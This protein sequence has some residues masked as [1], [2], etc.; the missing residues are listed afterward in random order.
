MKVLIA[1]PPLDTDKG[2]PLLSQ[3]RQFQYFKEPTY[4]YPV[5]PAS[6]ATMLKKS[7]HEVV[8]LD[9]IA[10][11]LSYEDFLKKVTE[12]KPDLIAL[13]T[14]TPVVKRHWQII[15]EL[16][17]RA[18]GL[19]PM[20]TVLFGDHV[21]ALPEESFLN[22]SVDYVLT[23][24]DYDFLLINLC[25]VLSHRPCL[26]G[27]Q[28]PTIDHRLFEPG[29]W[30][31]DNGQVKNTGLFKLD[32]D[33]DSA[34]VIDRDL[35]QWKLYAYK[36]G[37]F[38]RTPGAYIMAGR[39]CWWGKCT[40]CLEPAINITTNKGSIAIKDIVDKNHNFKNGLLVLTHEGIFRRVT[41]TYRHYYNGFL[42][43]LE[44]FCLKNRLKLTPNH[45]VFA[46][47]RSLMKRCSKKCSWSYLCVPGRIS[48]RL[49]CSKCQKQYYK[50]YLPSFIESEKLAKGDFVAV[51]IIRKVKDITCINIKD[52]LESEPPLV[53]TQKKKT[54][55]LIEEIVGEYK[56]GRSQRS[57]ARDL[58]IDRGTVKRYIGLHKSGQLN[59]NY[60]LIAEVD[61]YIKYEY[62]KKWISKRLF[63]S[64]DFLRLVGYY[65]AEGSVSKSGN[66]PNSYSISFTFSSKET[67]YITDVVKI[68]SKL[69][70]KIVVRQCLNQKNKTTQITIN[71]SILAILFLRL[72][73]A[74]SYEKKIPC[75]YLYL[76]LA[77]QRELLRGLFRGD[78][79]LRIRQKSKGGTE[80]ILETVSDVMANQILNI[81]FRFDAIPRFRLCPISKKRKSPVYS[82][83]LCQYDIEKVFRNIE[84]PGRSMKYRHGFILD[85]WA[86]VPIKD[87]TRE[88]YNGFLYNLEVGKDHSYVAGNV[89]V[90]N[91]SW[92]TLYPEFRS[93]KPENVVDEIEGLIND[94]GVK[95]IMDDSGCFPAGK[96]L[97]DFCEIMIKRGIGK[98]INLDCNMRFGALDLKQYKLMKQAGFR[99]VLFGLESANQ[100][101]L[102]HINKNVKADV[103]IDSCKMARQAGLYPHITI[104]FGYPWETYEDALR[105]LNLGRWLLK[106]GFAYTVQATIVIPYPGS[107]LFDECRD[108]GLLKSLDWE[109]YDM[110]APVMK[111]SI[112]DSKVKS[113]VQGI[114]SVAFDPEFIFNRIVSIRDLS[115]L[116]YFFRGVKKVSG[117]L[118]D[119]NK[120]GNL[121]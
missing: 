84:L 81:L 121:Q 53:N 37:N 39:D 43:N 20:A 107:K 70:K 58:Q 105:T 11:G 106:K 78:G 59:A 45:K 48:K 30:Y 115:D 74:N 5:V 49:D 104:M 46:I 120:L 108:S 35:T 110:K 16:K 100:V 13:E 96:W 26:A 113:L 69:W 111:T 51:P 40:F 88:S 63:L 36:N 90:S 8:W 24:G 25:S 118:F 41:K 33:L 44:L 87:I 101:T 18:D 62:G 2:V 97:N 10:S 23:G 72:F 42:L 67:R 85:D 27:R 7:G 4:I 77:K 76:P 119:F 82:I 61:G 112:D 50:R 103:I 109:D 117:H 75:S 56:M 19:W 55:E 92:P 65:L 86:M 54:D 52:F 28:E 114:Y 83:S 73:G 14:K 34:P 64:A 60:K 3:N 68:A 1:Y 80:Y 21:T 79:H 31:R 15:D 17:H 102:D 9:G 116:S 12:E 22:S 38:K 99:L 32:H 89:S 57:I 95:E 94:H 91:C 47:T 93:R 6:A 98:R 71:S 29:I 66:R